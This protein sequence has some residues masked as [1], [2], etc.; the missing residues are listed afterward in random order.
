MRT[1]HILCLLLILAAAGSAEE[2]QVQVTASADD[3]HAYGSAGLLTTFGYPRF[4]MNG[5]LEPYESAA[6]FV[7]LPIDSGALIDSAF[8]WF[9]AHSGLAGDSVVYV[10]AAEDTADA[11]AFSDRTDYNARLANLTAASLPVVL[12]STTSGNWYRSSDLAELIQSLV[13]RSDWQKDNSDVALFLRPT[14]ETPADVWFEVYHYDGDS[15]SAHKL[16]IFV[17]SDTS[18]SVLS[19]RRK[20]LIQSLLN[21]VR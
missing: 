8:L 2:V 4:G 12:Y 10:I 17:G 6:R 7:N 3:A 15:A 13:D 19:P 9:R 21:G 16:C 18:S 1:V 14:A 20:R 11:S 5:S